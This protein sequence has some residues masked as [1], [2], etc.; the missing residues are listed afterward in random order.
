[1]FHVSKIVT[2]ACI[3]RTIHG[4]LFPCST[5]QLVPTGESEGLHTQANSFVWCCWHWHWGQR[6]RNWGIPFGEYPPT[7]TTKSNPVPNISSLKLRTLSKRRV[8]LHVAKSQNLRKSFHVYFPKAN[9]SLSYR[10]SF[11]LWAHLRAWD[12]SA[13]CSQWSSLSYICFFTTF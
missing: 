12:I 2:W 13:L 11:G 10:S 3:P 9:P 5:M 4:F 1:M 7:H 8:S 6:A